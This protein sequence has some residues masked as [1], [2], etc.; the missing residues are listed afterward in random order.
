[1]TD[2]RIEKLCIHPRYTDLLP[3]DTKCMC[4][5][6]KF[7]RATAVSIADNPTITDEFPN[8]VHLGTIMAGIKARRALRRTFWEKTSSWFEGIP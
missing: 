3:P 4:K 7:L 8:G 1:M 2:P 5:M 6:C